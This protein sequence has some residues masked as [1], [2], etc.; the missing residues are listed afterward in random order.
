[1]RLDQYLAQQHPEHSRSTW[2]K[3]I[4]QGQVRV[5]TI[6]TTRAKQEVT[7]TDIVEIDEQTTS[8]YSKHTL[9]VIYEDDNVIVI[10]KPLGVLTHSKGAL[11]EEFTV[12]DFFQPKTTYAAE[13]NR[14]GIIHR[15][16][17]DTSGVMI[18]VKNEETARLLTRQFQD[19]RAKK[20]YYAVLDGQPKEYEANIDLP[21][22]RNPSLP[23]QHRVDPNGKS[24]QTHYVVEQTND[25]YSLVRLEPTTGRTHQL[26]VHMK[27]LGTPIVG[28]RVYGKEADRLYLHAAQ[29]E[30][31]IPN[32]DRRVFE[33]PIPPSFYEKIA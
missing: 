22:A 31:T 7:D 19:R 10:D 2:Q 24:A 4:K 30:I 27:Y 32:G 1:M 6:S 25:H 9:P 11:N 29:L 3:L 14:P 20:T 16:D 26:R 5:N 33:S 13:S 8:D 21:I 15:L 12:A 28:D 18:G 23:S 17:R